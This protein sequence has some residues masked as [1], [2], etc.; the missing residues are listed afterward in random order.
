MWVKIGP[1]DEE[2]R[3]FGGNN[4]NVEMFANLQLDLLAKLFDRRNMIDELKNM[5]VN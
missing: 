4:F 2:L 5:N 1:F 3:L